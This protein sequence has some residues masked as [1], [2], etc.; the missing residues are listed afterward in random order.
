MVCRMAARGQPLS[1]ARSLLV[2]TGELAM[3]ADGGRRTLDHILH[4]RPVREDVKVVLGAPALLLLLLLHAGTRRLV[5][6]LIPPYEAVGGRAE[7]GVRVRRV[8]ASCA[9]RQ[10][11]VVGK[12]LMSG[13]RGSRWVIM[14]PR[15]PPPR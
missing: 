15:G 10:G 7:S 9:E 2:R 14:S 3:G 5:P 6:S 13:L 4:T 12:V 8:A 11:V 1:Q